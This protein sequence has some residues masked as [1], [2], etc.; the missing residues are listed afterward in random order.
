MHLSKAREAEQKGQAADDAQTVGGHL[1]ELGESTKLA[2]ITSIRVDG[3]EPSIEILRH[4]LSDHQAAL[5]EAS[6][7]DLLEFEKLTNKVRGMHS[8]SLGRISSDDVL[9]TLTAP[10]A[11][12]TH[13]MM[14]ITI[15]KLY[16]RSGMP[17]DE[18][19]EATRGVWKMDC[20]GTRRNT[21][22]LSSGESS[23]RFIQSSDGSSQVP[24]NTRH[25]PRL[26]IWHRDV[27]SLS[28]NWLQM[29]FANGIADVQF[30]MCLDRHRRIRF[31]MYCADGENGEGTI[32]PAVLPAPTFLYRAAGASFPSS[33]I[34]LRSAH[35]GSYLFT[36]KA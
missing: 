22:A 7:I 15:N 19:Y 6:A 16:R 31:G 17:A 36:E 1:D 28:A 32:F 8:N 30:E 2:H 20:E 9:L 25:A 29:I 11:E 3:L 35:V 14:L 26:I 34:G 33:I 12:I 24:M 27:G 5:V 13:P 4:G 18:L 10:L 21:P 23:A